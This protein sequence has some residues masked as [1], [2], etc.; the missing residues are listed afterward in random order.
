VVN[1]DYGGLAAAAK[2]TSATLGGRD[3]PA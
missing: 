3:R 1:L 2:G